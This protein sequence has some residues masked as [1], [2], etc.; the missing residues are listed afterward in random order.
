MLKVSSLNYLIL[1]GFNFI[2]I[3]YSSK[4]KEIAVL[5]EDCNQFRMHESDCVSN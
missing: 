1:Y 2:I 4:E 3:K 5:E